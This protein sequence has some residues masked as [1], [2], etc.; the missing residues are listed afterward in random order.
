ML[1]FFPRDVLEEILNLIESVSEGF[2]SYSSIGEW[3]RCD[4]LK[5]TRYIIMCTALS[6][7]CISTIRTIFFQDCLNSAV[8]RD[9]GYCS[10]CRSCR[11]REFKSRKGHKYLP[12]YFSGE[13]C[14]L[15][16]W[17]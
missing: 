14:S 12:L 9:D 15:L 2:P 6:D 4:T 3:N 5:R 17:R 11:G 16:H 1:S 10:A 7:I 8:G 13:K